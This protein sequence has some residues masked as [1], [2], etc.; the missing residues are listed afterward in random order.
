MDITKPKPKCICVK[1]KPKCI[2]VPSGMCHSH[3]LLGCPHKHY[4]NDKN[5]WT[6]VIEYNN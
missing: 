5:I 3:T 6:C 2:C 1:P 4:F